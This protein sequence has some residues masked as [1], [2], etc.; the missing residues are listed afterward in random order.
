VRTR[1][2]AADRAQ[3][4]GAKM[5]TSRAHARALVRCY[6]GKDGDDVAPNDTGDARHRAPD[7]DV[8]VA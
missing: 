5:Y 1:V 8:A 6:A 3:V 2:R 7:R 4:P